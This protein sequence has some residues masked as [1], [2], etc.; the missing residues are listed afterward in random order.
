[1]DPV[2]VAPNFTQL[3]NMRTQQKAREDLG[4]NL[5]GENG[6][7]VLIPDDKNT[8]ISL[9]VNLSGS[10]SISPNTAEMGQVITGVNLSWSYNKPVLSQSLSNGIG[11]LS[12][13]SLR[14]YTHSPIVINT[15]T[16]YILTAG[17]GYTTINPSTSITYYHRRYWGVSINTSLTD[18]EIKMGST[19]LSNSKS[20]SITYNCTGGRRFWYAYPTY[21]GLAS[22]TV[23]GFPFSGWIG[24]TT[25]QTI[26]IT[27]AY[28]YTENYYY[29]MVSN[30]QNGASIPTNFS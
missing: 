20:K 30:I 13:L 11:T 15:N 28:G 4:A 8:I 24:G 23:N 9:H 22:V 18:T 10:L 21:L 16:S 1:V 27:N 2:T 12:P 14:N 3:V 17:D 29:Y 26:S 6:I 7:D 25:P 19:E 5:I